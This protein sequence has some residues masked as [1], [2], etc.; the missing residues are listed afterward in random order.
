MAGKKCYL[1]DD[2]YML[3]STLHQNIQNGEK[4]IFGLGS[5]QGNTLKI[6]LQM[7]PEP[8]VENLQKNGDKDTCPYCKNTGKIRFMRQDGTF[9][10][11]LDCKHGQQALTYI[12]RLPLLQRSAH[13]EIIGVRVTLI[14]HFRSH[15][16]PRAN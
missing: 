7:P 16:Q 10:E 5:K 14:F 9:T 6:R 15:I 2:A 4:C 8:R 11:P 13:P 1:Y 12:Q 3:H